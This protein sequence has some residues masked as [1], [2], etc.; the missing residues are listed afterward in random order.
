MSPTWLPRTSLRSGELLGGHAG[1]SYN[2]GTG[3]GYSVREILSA[4]NAEVG[5]PV[6]MLQ[7]IDGLE[8]R[9]S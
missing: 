4:I 6:P 3:V 7:K 8:I 1:G 2:L 9:L 5:R